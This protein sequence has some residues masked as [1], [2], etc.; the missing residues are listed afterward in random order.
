MVHNTT[1]VTLFI[2]GG[3]QCPLSIAIVPG[4]DTTTSTS[5]SAPLNCSGAGAVQLAVR[6]SV[7]FTQIISA[8]SL[9]MYQPGAYSVEVSVLSAQST[10]FTGASYVTTVSAGAIE[11][12]LGQ[13]VGVQP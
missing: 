1:N 4:S 3:G 5:R 13:A 2:A 8:A 7:V 12:P 9:A 11:L 6:D 10:D